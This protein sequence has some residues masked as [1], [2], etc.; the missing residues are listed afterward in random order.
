MLAT[1]RAP[2]PL[3]VRAPADPWQPALAIVDDEA[4]FLIL[5]EWGARRSGLFRQI[6]TLAGSESAETFF[7]G[8]REGANLPDAVLIDWR[9]PHLNGLELIG[10]LRKQP[11]LSSTPLVALSSVVSEPDHR[12]ALEAGCSAFLLKP[13]GLEAMLRVCSR[14]RSL[15]RAPSQA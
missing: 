5:M 11:L 10:L 7:A 1:P 6:H 3:P 4:D 14:V 2:S 15:C 13:F 9:M 8:T 12:A